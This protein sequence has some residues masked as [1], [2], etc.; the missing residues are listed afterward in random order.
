MRPTLL[1]TA[2]AL[3]TFAIL[4]LQAAQPHSLSFTALGT[5]QSGLFE[6]GAAE[7]VAH[8]AGS[9]RL[10]VVNAASGR[11]D[12]LDIRNPAQPSLLH[13]I[14]LS[15]YG[16]S[17][18]SVAVHKGLVAAAVENAVKTEPGQVVLLD[19]DGQVRGAVRVGAL[20]DMLVFS[21]DGH[22]LLVANEGEPSDDYQSDPEGSVSII[23]LPPRL[24]RLSQ[25][26]VR[27]AHFRDIRREQLDAS[28]RI[29]GPNAS[30]AQD[31]EPEYITLSKDGRRAWVTLQENNAI[32][33]IDVERARVLKVRGLG[34][35]DHSQAGNELDASDKDNAVNIRNWPVRG[36]YQ[37]DAL[38][39]FRHHGRTYLVTAN[40][41]DA[42]AYSGFNEEVRVGSA[43]YLLD[44]ARFPEAATLEQN[45][46]LGRLT[47][48][49]ASGLNPQTGTYEA[50]YAFG[51][52]SFS[53][54]DARS[55]EQVWDSGSAFER[56]GAERMPALFNSNHKENARD[57]R[58]DDKGPEP[59][60]VTVARL[61]GTPY[62][63]IGLERLSAVMVYDLAKPSA[64][65]FVE[66]VGTRNAEVAPPAAEA[67]DLGPEGV[68]VIGAAHSPIP[69]VP[70]LVVG[71][72]VSGTTTLYRIDR[73]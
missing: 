53:L 26:Q 27:T 24:E 67:G 62:A 68:M 58:S 29:F 21:H 6:Q 35:K 20:P 4:P 54:W 33:E 40:E 12:V 11:I 28:V 19:V 45:A 61:W 37:P 52:R 31:L 36:L 1:A 25:R 16:R 46:N 39:S 17:V 30:V 73:R 55:L 10:F 2:L 43:S 51:A 71:N 60:G 44:P 57:G 9:Q 65:R 5:Y 66:M 13:S 14:D 48:S 15:A 56:I 63:F 32:A 47:V 64:P 7:I 8:D 38:A 42:R 18:N 50:I 23:D 69:G 70:L 49:R 59:E 22:R 41:G 3:S 72:E 34:Y